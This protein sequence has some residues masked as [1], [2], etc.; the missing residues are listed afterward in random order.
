MTLR[1]NVELPVEYEWVNRYG[2]RGIGLFRSEFLL[3]HRGSMPGEVWFYLETERALSNLCRFP[4]FR[5]M[6]N[7]AVPH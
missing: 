2:A 5:F 6:G 1:A 7:N 4:G 3:S